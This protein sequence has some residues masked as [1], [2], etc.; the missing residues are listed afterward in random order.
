MKKTGIANIRKDY[1]SGSLDISNVNADPICQFGLWITEVLE[2]R[3]DE[4]NAMMLATTGTDL[5][6]SARIVLLR[7][8]SEDGFVFYTNYKSLKGKQIDE[9]PKAALTFF[10]KELERQVRIEGN[11]VKLPDELSE[12]YFH[13]RPF[14]SRLSAVVSPQSKAIRNREY[15]ENMREGLREQFPK[16]DIPKPKDWGGYVVKPI[17]IEFWQGRAGRLHDRIL[18]TSAGNHWKIERLAP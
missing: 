12:K 4:P 13:S 18:Y 16:Q 9:N 11:I 17:S 8:F 7:D 1:T 5:Q 10:W 15:L 14:E 2:A 3:I 6:P